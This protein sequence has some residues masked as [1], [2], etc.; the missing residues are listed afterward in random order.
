MYCSKCGKN[1]PDNSQNCN[2]CGAPTNAPQSASNQS[3]YIQEDTSPLS[4]GNFLV[5]MLIA[6]IPILNIIMLCVWAFGSGS[7]VN[8]K[9]YARAQ[10]IIM[11]I[12]M[13]VS[14]VL[15]SSLIGLLISISNY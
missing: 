3:P 6:A 12:A 4:V 1:I 13:A 8:R 7:N 11:L 14:I 2:Y 10:L 5:M 9:N 15:W